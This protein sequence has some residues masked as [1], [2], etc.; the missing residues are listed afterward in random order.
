MGCRLFGY[1][2]CGFG[3]TFA[4]SG[5]LIQGWYKEDVWSMFSRGG[6]GMGDKRGCLPVDR[7]VTGVPRV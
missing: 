2:A 1:R 7:R 3:L 4:L 6:G 5:W